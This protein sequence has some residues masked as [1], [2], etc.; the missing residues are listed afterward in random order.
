[1]MVSDLFMAFSFDQTRQSE[2]CPW[3]SSGTFINLLTSPTTVGLRS[4]L[5]KKYYLHNLGRGP[6]VLIL[7]EQRITDT[8][9]TAVPLYW[10]Y[11]IG[12]T[13]FL[14]CV[15]PPHGL[16]PLYALFNACTTRAYDFM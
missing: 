7:S 16:A 6:F 2:K 3:S 12:L 13:G 10:L 15:P 5:L 1:M 4:P 9:A 11:P 14:Y 8:L